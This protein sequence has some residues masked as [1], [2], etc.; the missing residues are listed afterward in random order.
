MPFSHRKIAASGSRFWLEIICRYA[1][2]LSEHFCYICVWYVIS[3]AMNFEKAKEFLQSFVSY[4]GMAKIPYSE[5]V[6]DLRKIKNFLRDY[7]VD[8]EKLKYVHVAG[9]K[10]KGST[11]SFIANYLWRRG[12]KVGLYTSPH[13]FEITERIWLNGKEIDKKKFS[14]MVEN[15]KKFIAKN[16]C[17][18]LTYFEI[19]TVLALKYFV[20]EGVDYAVLEVGLGGRLDATNIVKPVLSI[21]T[22]VELEH[23]DVLGDTF[24]KILNEKLGIVKE[25]V[26]LLIGSQNIEVEKIIRKK[27]A[28]KKGVFYLESK[29]GFARAENENLAFHAL[30]LFLPKVDKEKFFRIVEK[31]KLPGRFD[32]RKVGKCKVIFDMAHTKNSIDDLLKN[33]ER[34]FGKKKFVF[35]F[36]L[37][38]GK[39]VVSI[40]KSIGNC[41]EKIVFTNAHEVRG[42]PALELKNLAI[43]LGVKRQMEVVEDCLKAFKNMQK[44]NRLLVVTGSHFLIGKILSTL[45]S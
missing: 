36:A 40:L 25:N 38:K 30:K 12:Y 39:D 22:K 34:K 32:V 10:G 27:L 17:E 24:E 19:L 31:V 2:F 20:D 29:N 42:M 14:V 23:T 3:E 7:G 45:L 41:A 4:E 43:K 37:M 1:S 26:P 28:D 8:Y 9:S 5:K 6:F 11:C 16:K 21:L 33:L 15:L 18:K 13:I 44:K 35:L